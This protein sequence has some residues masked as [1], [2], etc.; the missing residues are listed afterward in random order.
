MNSKELYNV[1]LDSAGVITDSRIDAP[2]KIFFALRGN[3]FD[4]NCFV[5]DALSNGCSFAVI[6]NKDHA[7][8]GKTILVS[9]VLDSLQM[10]ARHHRQQFDIP[11]FAITGSNGK[12]TTKELIKTVMSSR[13]ETLATS[14]NL[15]NHIGVPLTLLELNSS[16]Q[17]AV[18]EM[19]ANHQ[20][21]IASLCEI[22]MPTHGLITNIGTAHL[23]GFGSKEGV[24]RA[25]GELFVYLKKKGGKAFFNYDRNEL[26]NLVLELDLDYISYGS[27][28][29]RFVSGILLDSH[30]RLELVISV[31]EHNEY[32]VLKTNLPG[33]YNFEN[34]LAAVCSGIWFGI[35]S[36]QIKKAIEE[37]YPVNNRSQIFETSQNRL[38]LDAYNA[39]PD[40]MRAAIQ[41]FS[42]MPGD[43]KSVILGDM[44]ELGEYADDEHKKVIEILKAHDFREVILVGCVFF[45]IPSPKEYLHLENSDKLIEWLTHNPL[46]NRFILLKGSRG[47][48]L[49][50]CISVL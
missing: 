39:N 23:E 30:D 31:N 47:V 10:L 20:G 9:N 45:N 44:L 3:S 12:T 26:R 38:L 11:V 35:S 18:I 24:L 7:V 32:F 13:F 17:F 14:G 36:R 22:A 34:V 8:S 37:Y 27:G 1:F 42:S 2:G 43:N 28:A 40:S 25:K 15:N 48:K 21:E 46:R 16:H 5:D 19:G 50:M 4:G 49:E 6:D 29:D 33:A 41:S